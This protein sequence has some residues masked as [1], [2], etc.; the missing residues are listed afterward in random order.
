MSKV[1]AGVVGIVALG[2]IGLVTCTTKIDRGH[3]GVVYDQFNGGVQEKVLTSG[4]Q[5]KT[6]WQKVNEF[7]TVTKTMYMSADKKDGSKDNEA[8]SI[9]SKD[10]DLE[11]DFTMMYSFDAKNVVK[12]QKEFMQ[13]ADFIVNEQLRG[14]IKGLVSEATSKFSTREI[15]QSNIEAVNK[16]VTEHLQKRAEAYG[17]TVKSVKLTNPV[18]SKAFLKAIEEQRTAE[19]KRKVKEDELESTKLDN[20]RLRIEGQ[21]LVER[22]KLEKEANEIKS[23]G[24]TPEILE[25]MKIKEWDGKLSIVQGQGVNPIIKID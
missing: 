3:V 14:E 17:I 21:G 24:L 2:A 6:P 16:A 18:P 9:R 12:V 4:R 20:E 8:I 25:E 13:S 10:G 23:K 19:Q 5:F 11:V 22:A 1:K 7:P 15:Y